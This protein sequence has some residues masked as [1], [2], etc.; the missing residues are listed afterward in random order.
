MSFDDEE[1]ISL[2][3]HA[4]AALAEFHAE[5]DA[6]RK[7]FEKLKT[8]VA[9][10]SRSRV[11]GSSAPEETTMWKKKRTTPRTRTRISSR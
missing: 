3:S 11:R 2:S 8:G 1:P 6:H 4:L 5:K 9:P 7:T 10:Q